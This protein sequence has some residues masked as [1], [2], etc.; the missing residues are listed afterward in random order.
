MRTRLFPARFAETA[1]TSVSSETQSFGRE[2]RGFHAWPVIEV[3]LV[4]LCLSFAIPASLQGSPLESEEVGGFSRE[5]LD[6]PA[7]SDF[8]AGRSSDAE[9][10]E[11]ESEEAEGEVDWESPSYH[12]LAGAIDTFSSIPNPALDDPRPRNQRNRQRV[13]SVEKVFECEEQFSQLISD[14]PDSPAAREAHY[15]LGECQRLLGSPE[16]AIEEFGIALPTDGG[17]RQG[18]AIRLSW[19]RCLIEMGFFTRALSKLDEITQKYSDS[20][21]VPMALYLRGIA[22]RELEDYSAAEEAW[23]QLISESRV[24]EAAK[25]AKLNRESLCPVRQRLRLWI[26]EFESAK[27]E[28]E[29]VPKASKR[30]ALTD[31]EKA[32][33]RIGTARGPETAHYLL[34]LLKTE[35]P[36]IQALVVSPLITAGGSRAAEQLAKQVKK[37]DDQT[38]QAYYSSLRKQHLERIKVTQFTDDLS[39]RT[40]ATALSVIDLFG[41]DGSPA[42]VRVLTKTIPAENSLEELRGDVL[43]RTDR[44]GRQIRRLRDPKSVLLLTKMLSSAKAPSLRRT[45]CAEALGYTRSNAAIEP[46]R[47]ALF[48]RNSQVASAAARSLGRLKATESIEDLRRLLIDRRADLPFLKDAVRALTGMD[49]SSAEH[50]LIAISDADDVALR[51]VVIRALAKIGHG[52]SLDRVIEALHD[53][54]WQVRSAAIHSTEGVRKAEYVERLVSLLE[55]EDGAM[56]PLIIRR[57]ISLLGVDKG[58]NPKMWREQW[59]FAKRDWDEETVVA[60]GDGD[61]EKGSTFVWKA[62]PD[63]VQSPSYFG[64]EIIS[65]NLVFIIDISGSMS[66]EVTVPNDDGGST[67]MRRIDLAKRELIRAV[68]LLEPRTR[69]NIIKFNNTPSSWSKKLQLF[70]KKSV[71]S[72]RRYAEGLSPSGSTNIFDSLAMVLEAGEVDTIYLL[73]DGAPSAGRITTPTGILSEIK[74]MNAEYQVTIHTIAM[75]YESSFLR[76]LAEQNNGQYVVAGK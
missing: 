40:M 39:S 54:A 4:V 9:E 35:E 46:L 6:T 47:N 42:A 19:A 37:L 32:L 74:K 66:A 75:A 69:F 14:F 68:E 55:R 71:K 28:Y 73:T 12:A 59:E 44:I 21:E 53:P 57:L 27:R 58:P 16:L 38:L 72:A 61:D 30:S 7:A 76:D 15:W 23:D 67:T 5:N 33:N 41:R 20:L 43:R 26:P 63:A 65:K 13:D 25:L 36:A 22:F 70:S 8:F 45:L 29:R 31:V 1:P 2:S 56:R 60:E 24:D 34:G 11:E 64:V 52:A 18:A 62:D 50:Q 17:G 51:V 3:F 49:P 48:D 10:D